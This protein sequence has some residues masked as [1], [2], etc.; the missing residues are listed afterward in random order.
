V[1]IAP[2]PGSRPVRA[3]LAAVVLVAT[4]VVAAPA[5]AGAPPVVFGVGGWTLPAPSTLAQLHRAGLRT[6]RL[7]MSWSAVSPSSPAEN[8]SG[9][10]LVMRAAA[11]NRIEVLV[12][13]T[14]CPSWACPQ[15]G[16]PT[17]SAA[18]A[19]FRAF[20]RNA[21]RRYGHGGS[22]WRRHRADPVVY[23][24]VFNEVNGS[25]Q[26]SPAP[27][28]AAYARVLAATASTIRHTDRRA[29]VVLA[30]LAE[31]MTI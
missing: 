5:S 24:Q 17:A 22:L 6:W 29:K 27:S 23:W 13:L 31:R 2:R 4:L 16:P 25:D 20:V 19:G 11:A 12:T 3:T 21:V 28:A 9:Y 15:G 8:F 18:L 1:A 10:D 14:G 7:T 30:G 26:W